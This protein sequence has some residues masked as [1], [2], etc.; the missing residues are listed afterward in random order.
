MV[1][2]KCI[3][4]GY[5]TEH[6]TKMR[7]HLDRKIICN[8]VLQ[9]INLDHYRND[10]LEIKKNIITENCAKNKQSCAKNKQS[11]AET[12]PS[13]AILH[14]NTEILSNLDNQNCYDFACKFCLNK[15]KLK[16]SLN[17]HWK[18]CKAKIE[19]EEA[20]INNKI[21]IN[22]LN[23]QIEQQ[24]KQ[25]ASQQ[26][27]ITNITNNSQSNSHNTNN[28]QINVNID[29]RRLSY[30]NTNYDAL[31]DKDIQQSLNRAG[32]CIQ[33]IIALTHFNPKHP[34]NQNI[35]ISCLKSAVALLFEDEKWN[36]H[37]WDDVSDR[38]VDNSII[39][40]QDWLDQNKDK[41]PRLAEKFQIFVDKREGDDDKFSVNLKRAIKLVLYN[42]RNMIRSS[43]MIKLLQES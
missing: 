39:T 29:K 32:R 30:K 17:R 28:V 25:I 16:S 36:A 24:N 41:H 13:C 9:D 3:R 37:L 26:T 21:L 34:E 33:E 27:Q 20:D 10:I 38:V 40:I 7:L 31:T 19:Q 8:P 6:K 5:L 4:C 43:D 12:E 11:C 35:Y 23:D 1:Q 42:G 22:K 18:T 15:Y 14:Q 2:Y